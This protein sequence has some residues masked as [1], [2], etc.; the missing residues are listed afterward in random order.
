MAG[1]AT[2]KVTVRLPISAIESAMRA[3]GQGLTLT[4]IE[5]LHEV[6]RRGKRTALRK[7]R[8]KVQFDLSLE[9]TRR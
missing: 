7:L 3:T 8:G 4:L 1:Q 9:E 2:R 5:G 6:E